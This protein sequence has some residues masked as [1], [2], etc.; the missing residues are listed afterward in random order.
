M[1]KWMFGLLGTVLMAV[2]AQ[3]GTVAPQLQAALSKSVP[4]EEVA[5]I[6]KFF[7]RLDLT[8][9]RDP[10]PRRRRARMIRELKQI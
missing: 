3:A 1:K 10:N 2:A 9:C 5:I 7:D 4:G 6:I 8:A